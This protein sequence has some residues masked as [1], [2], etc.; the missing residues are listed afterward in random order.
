MSSARKKIAKKKHA[1]RKTLARRV[2]AERAAKKKAATKKRPAR[3]RTTTPPKPRAAK[4]AAKKVRTKAGRAA[5]KK[6]AT[7]KRGRAS[8]LRSPTPPAMPPELAG[9]EAHRE[10]ARERQAT[11]SKSGRDIAPL[12][13]IEDP[14][15]RTRC[16]RDFRAFC[17]EYFPQRFYLPWSND[18]LRVIAR[19][20]RAVLAGDLFAMAMARGSGKTSLCE[21]ACLWAEGYGHCNFVAL[22]GADKGLAVDMLDS[23]KT[24]LELNERLAA[25]F[26]EICYPIQRLDGITQRAKG[27]LCEGK[28][29][30]ISW[31][32]DQI[33]LPSIPGSRASGGIIRVAGLTGR[34]RGMKYV[35]PDGETVRPDLVLV[36]DPQTDET[37][38][39]ITQNEQR[40]RI[41]AGAILGL[42]GPG[43]RIAG[44]LTVTVIVQ[45][46]MADRILDRTK[47]PDWNSERCKMVYRWPTNEKLWEQYAQIRADGLLNEDGGK[48]ATAFYRKHRKAMDEG[49]EVAWPERFHPTELSA[50]QHAWNLRLRDEGTF[51]AEYQNE[52]LDLN[53]DAADR[54]DDDALAGKIAGVARGVIPQACHQLVAFIDVQDKVLWWIV[55]AFGDNFTGAIV[56]YAAWPDQGRRYF[57]NRDA[58]RTL[59]RAFPG[60]GFEGKI[61]NG[62]Q[63]LT[64]E[65]CSR[66]WRNEGATELAITRIIIDANWGRSTDIVYQFCRESDRRALLL[67]SHG[68]GIGAS[69]KPLNEYDKK[70]GDR[71]GQQWRIPVGSGRRASRHM[72]FDAN[73]WKSFIA[74][75]L[76]AAHGDQGSLAICKG[77]AAEHRMLFEHLTAEYPVATQGR[78][79]QVDE[80]K[81]SPGRDNHLWDCIV[82]AAVAAS[83]EGITALGHKAKTGKKRKRIRLAPGRATVGTN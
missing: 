39:S 74:D 21:V 48:A 77:T 28:R 55:C 83:I 63:Q 5:K 64:E 67:P 3:K 82:G 65:L 25:D 32:V 26:P 27:Q 23:I 78:G 2:R 20:E 33:I 52:P 59:G 57:T 8:G 38:K 49:A 46:D 45:D 70:P 58:R 9:Y 69:Q 60:A 13:A 61:Y 42:A 51:F 6:A 76:R 7:K 31:R 40:E 30:R 71:V 10:R 14:E 80:W 53:P 79:R 22:I 17:D 1:A 24:E 4:P 81:L 66:P 41:L 12:P 37:A 73:W 68:R 34:I 72:I 50:I 29:T 19:I 56:D 15:R 36:D 18:H 75:R 62:L 16:E 35:R 54:L 43:K 44:L 47:H 11:Q